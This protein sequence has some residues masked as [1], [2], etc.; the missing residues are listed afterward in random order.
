[1]P[2]VLQQ[3]GSRR[4]DGRNRSVNCS[5][6]QPQRNIRGKAEGRRLLRKLGGDTLNSKQRRQLQS[7]K[8]QV[9]LIELG[10]QERSHMKLA[11][12]MTGG[13]W[14]L[15]ADAPRRLSSSRGRAE[16]KF[17]GGA[18]LRLDLGGYER[19]H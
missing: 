19:G 14:G 2:T 9:A 10:A 6:Q 5:G 13:E 11:S 4:H 18:F 15:V 17:D 8:K 1:M 3:P 16:T 12:G 7:R